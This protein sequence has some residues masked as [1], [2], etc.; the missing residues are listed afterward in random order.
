MYFQLIIEMMRRQWFTYNCREIEYVSEMIKESNLD[1]SEDFSP[2]IA[3]YRFMSLLNS[4][5]PWTFVQFR[6]SDSLADNI[7]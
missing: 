3:V 1:H 5:S 2:F 7:H 6:T 4:Q